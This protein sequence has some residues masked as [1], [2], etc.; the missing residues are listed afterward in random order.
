MPERAAA[1]RPSGPGTPAFPFQNVTVV[2]NRLPVRIVRG[3]AGASVQPGSGGLVTALTP[4]L[5]RHGGQWIG[6]DGDIKG[7]ASPSWKGGAR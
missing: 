3:R 7:G 2:S 4:V 6:W 1:P 5:Q